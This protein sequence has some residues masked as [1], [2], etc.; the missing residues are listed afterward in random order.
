ML[1]T[2]V[3]TALCLLAG[4]LAAL[5]L[6][7]PL[8][9]LGLCGL[10]AATAGWEWSGLFGVAKVVRAVQAVGFG[11][12]TVGFGVWAGLAAPALSANQ[13]LLIV[14]LVAGLFWLGCVPLW[15]AKKWS[16][17][18]GG[19][20]FVLGMVV[21]I[22]AALALA[23][24]RQAGQGAVLGAMAG[25]WLAD[26]AAYFV[27]RAIG[28][29]KLAPNISPGKSWEGVAGAVCCVMSYVIIVAFAFFDLEP[30]L[31]HLLA[32]ALGGVVFTG[33][34]VEGDLYESL[35]KRKAGVKDSGSILPGHG[36]LLDRIDSL[37]ST[38]PLVGAVLILL[39]RG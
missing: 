10:V 32:V 37:T 9:W 14:Y 34:S 7:P 28:Q 12:L 16:I 36:G 13:P 33:V 26:I 20:S 35:L 8:G 25:V 22:P 31:D 30:T 5:F 18:G 24:L 38:L 3:I 19:P 23:H 4:F 2:R 27:G 15:L 1:K 39:Q 29:R 11:A 6:L 21:L 17:S